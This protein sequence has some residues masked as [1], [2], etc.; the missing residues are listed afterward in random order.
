M[1]E[2]QVRDL[3][4]IVQSQN[5]W[6]LH[7]TINLIASENVM[8]ERARALDYRYSSCGLCTGNPGT[9]SDKCQYKSRS[10]SYSKYKANHGT[11]LRNKFSLCWSRAAAQEP[12]RVVKSGFAGRAAV[13]GLRLCFVE[14]LAL[15]TKQW[16]TYR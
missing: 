13:A 2:D 10:R 1:L 12:G 9:R 15:A 14:S 3:E 6:R 8:S 7:K 5:D 11:P 4:R 16:V